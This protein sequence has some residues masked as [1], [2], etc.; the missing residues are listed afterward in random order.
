MVENCQKILNLK[1][2]SPPLVALQ[3]LR[4]LLKRKTSIQ[5]WREVGEYIQH[6]AWWR[7][8]KKKHIAAHKMRICFQNLC[9][10][11]PNLAR[12]RL[13]YIS[14]QQQFSVYLIKSKKMQ[15]H[16]KMLIKNVFIFRLF[17]HI[18]I[19]FSLFKKFFVR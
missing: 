19:K 15:Q 4:T 17:L 2:F 5:W 16:Q 6:I 7:G 11:S 1:N 13:K 12:L 8:Y 18:I 9:Y 14:L 3:F 10:I